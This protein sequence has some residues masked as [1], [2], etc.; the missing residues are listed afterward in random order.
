MSKQDTL[1]AEAKHKYKTDKPIN[2]S[3]NLFDLM[4]FNS[5]AYVPDEQSVC[6]ELLRR[7]HDNALAGHFTVKK[8]INL[9]S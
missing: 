5:K 3:I 9:L 2:W 8:T 7:Y 6:S 1:L 4:R